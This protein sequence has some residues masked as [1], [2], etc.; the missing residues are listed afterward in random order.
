MSN[1]LWIARREL[2]A[3]LRSPLGYVVAAAVLLIDGIWFIAKAMGPAGDKRLSAAVL[4]EFFH[5]ATGTTMIACIALAM[6][7]IAQEQEQGTLVLLR[8]SPVRDRDIVLGKF[9]SVWLV[10][11]LITVLSV[12]MPALIFVRGRVSI[13]HIL[14]GYTGV[15]LLAAASTAI[16]V[17]ASAIARSQVIAAILGAVVL[18]T[19]V[20]LW[21]V[22]RI[23]EPPL[24][25]FIETLALH[26]VHQ[27]QFMAGVLRLE[28]V[29]Y[30]LVVTFFFLL[31][32]VK[33]LEVRRWR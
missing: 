21:M 13:G 12:Y 5:G 8:T 2:K 17:F 9:L 30:Y 32:A 27:R 14:V 15:L 11:L 23:S 1:V 18:G 16:G 28:H 31:A 29:V 26:H 19:M 24:N 4:S 33:T 25:G 10:M 3:Y 22:A 6:R 7:L 20:L